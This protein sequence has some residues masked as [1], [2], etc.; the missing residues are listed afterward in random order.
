M[1]GIGLDLCAGLFYEHRFAM[2][3]MNNGFCRTPVQSIYI[4]GPER[5]Y[6]KVRKHWRGRYCIIQGLPLIHIR[7][8]RP[9][10]PPDIHLDEEELGVS[11]QSCSIRSHI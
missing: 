11:R 2:L 10:L 5:K 9:K 7:Q 4:S 1:D 6:L 3:I 8:M